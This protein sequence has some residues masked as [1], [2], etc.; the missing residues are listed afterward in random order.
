[1]LCMVTLIL[2]VMGVRASQKGNVS[3]LNYYY[4]YYCAIGLY[5]NSAA[6]KFIYLALQLNQLPLALA[7]E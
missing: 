4:Y 1:M 6:P 2:A 3:F 5:I 7:P